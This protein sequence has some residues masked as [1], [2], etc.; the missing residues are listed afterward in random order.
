IKEG[1]GVY[2]GADGTVFD[3]IWVSDKFT[4]SN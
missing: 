3:G 4:G 1:K 2:R